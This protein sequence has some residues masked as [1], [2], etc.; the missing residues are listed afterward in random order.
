MR[1][2]K[3][4]RGISHKITVGKFENITPT[5]YMEAELDLGEDPRVAQAELDKLTREIWN[6]IAMD[7][8][9]FTV[10]RRK[11]EGK[12][13]QVAEIALNAFK[14]LVGGQGS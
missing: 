12:E 14:Q 10:Q 9:R 3:V 1:V 6:T 5:W 7:E 2:T 11:L 4:H 13:F 8:L